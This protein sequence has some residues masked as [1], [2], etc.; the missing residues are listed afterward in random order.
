[1]AFLYT[2]DKQAELFFL[3]SNETIM[4]FVLVFFICFYSEFL[5]FPILK[6]PGIFGTKPTYYG[7]FF[8]FF[9]YSWIQFSRILFSIFDLD[10]K[11]C[12]ENTA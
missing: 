3:A 1:M 11:V 9:M 5:N 8:L 12:S 7:E 4:C 2:M 6:Y 10:R